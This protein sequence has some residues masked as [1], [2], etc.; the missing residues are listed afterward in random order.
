MSFEQTSGLK[1]GAPGSAEP[2]IAISDPSAAAE[3]NATSLEKAVIGFSK[4]AAWIFPILMLAIV[5]QVILR[6]MGANQAWLDDAHWWMYGFAMVVGLGYAVTTDSHVRVDILHQNYSEPRKSRI[7]LFALGW[8]FLPFLALM[9]DLLFHYA[10]SSWTAGEGSDSPNGLHMLY[11][12]KASLPI[13]FSL[14]II[15]GLGAARRH[16][17]TVTSS[18]ALWKWLIA[19]LPFAWFVAERAIMYA[20]WWFVR[21]TKP[22]LHFRRVIRDD[23]LQHTQLAALAVLIALFAVSLVMSRAKRTAA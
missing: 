23:L 14:A 6:K 20:L 8:L 17:E 3:A 4:L 18:P 12:L 2:E 11:L 7:E 10:A 5:A 15:A 13:L 9:T 1:A 22:E 21:F 16:M 19:L